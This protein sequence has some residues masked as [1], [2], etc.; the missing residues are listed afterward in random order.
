MTRQAKTPGQRAQEALGIAQRR[1]SRIETD[2]K[3]AKAALELLQKEYAQAVA[4]RDYLAQNPDLPKGNQSTVTSA[5]A[6]PDVLKGI[7][8]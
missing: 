8:S 5:V 3:K 1:V 7:S 2:Q 4:R 6:S